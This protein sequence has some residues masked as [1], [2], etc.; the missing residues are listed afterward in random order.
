MPAQT[1]LLPAGGET[2][3]GPSPSVATLRTCT[4]FND[5]TEP[6]LTSLAQVSSW[7]SFKAGDT[8]VRQSAQPDRVFLVVAGFVKVLVGGDR[9]TEVPRGAKGERRSG[10]RPEVMLALLG[11]GDM[12]GEIALLLDTGRS[13]SLVALT[14]CQVVGVPGPAFMALMRQSA[15][16]ALA[17]SRKLAQRLVD[18]NQATQLLHSPLEA[19]VLAMLRHCERMGLDSQRWLSNAE[20]AR[21]VGASRVAVSQVMT[22]LR[23]GAKGS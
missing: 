15:P 20:L 2:A 12:A 17:V 14:P 4:L 7:T 10:V 18:A 5:L 13:A 16:L 22:R 8:V 6:Q 1:D 19:R 21:M 23:P 11:P 9:Q 3:A